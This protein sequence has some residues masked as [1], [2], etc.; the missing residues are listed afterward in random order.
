MVDVQM[1][2]EAVEGAAGA[3]DHSAEILEDMMSRSSKIA[4]SLR[5]GAMK[6]KAGEE[7]ANSFDSRLNAS[8]RRMQEKFTEMEDDLRKAVEAT[9]EALEQSG[10]RYAQ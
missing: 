1:D 7:L 5:D 2:F 9:R 6:G 4:A 3:Y 10:S 8:L